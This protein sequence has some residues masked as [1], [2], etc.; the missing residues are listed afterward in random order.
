MAD[1]ST[2]PTSDLFSADDNPFGD[3]E[4]AAPPP[5][6]PVEPVKIVPRRERWWKLLGL[7]EST[8]TRDGYA[9]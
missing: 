4:F 7:P 5:S 6:S 1:S 2:E 3:D 8:T 9:N